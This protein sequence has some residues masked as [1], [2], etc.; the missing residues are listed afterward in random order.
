MKATHRSDKLDSLL[1]KR[2]RITFYDSTIATGYLLFNKIC[3]EP[4]YLKR[5]CYYVLQRNGVYLGFRKS[6]I[7]RVELWEG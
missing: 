3:T 7:K 5:G 2:V 4:L 1:G 6:H